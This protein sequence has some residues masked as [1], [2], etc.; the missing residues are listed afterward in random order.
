MFTQITSHHIFKQCERSTGNV[1]ASIFSQLKLLD[2]G[3]KG[4]EFLQSEIRRP[5]F[6][7]WL[8]GEVC[9]LTKLF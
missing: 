3:G 7:Q 9:L 6:D 1:N 2:N 4:K 8:S 5:D